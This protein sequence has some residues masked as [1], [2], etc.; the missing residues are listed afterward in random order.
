MSEYDS[1]KLS[2]LSRIQFKL[3][4]IKYS[5]K[6]G[7]SEERR[8]VLKTQSIWIDIGDLIEEKGNENQ[9]LPIKQFKKHKPNKCV[10]VRKKKPFQ[11]QESQWW[12]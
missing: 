1:V 10:C 9:I 2:A 5:I 11:S 7:T 6:N 8:D 3:R 12:Q 4:E